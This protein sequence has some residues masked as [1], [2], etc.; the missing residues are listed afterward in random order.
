MQ[1]NSL[2]SGL[3]SPEK[4]VKV[5]SFMLLDS[6]LSLPEG[7]K[8]YLCSFSLQKGQSTK[9][10]QIGVISTKPQFVELSTI[11]HQK[12]TLYNSSN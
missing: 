1:H 10:T 4:T 3:V 9:Y 5:V 12:N 8:S 6:S 7:T 11:F 2:P